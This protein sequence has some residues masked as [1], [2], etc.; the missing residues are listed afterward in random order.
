MRKSESTNGTNAAEK[1]SDS[2][3]SPALTPVAQVA[4]HTPAAAAR[5]I[6]ASSGN[7]QG[8]K[9]ATRPSNG[10]GDVRWSRNFLAGKT[11][12]KPDYEDV[13]GVA[14]TKAASVQLLKASDQYFFY[15]L[16]GPGGRL[17][18]HPIVDKG[19]LP[20][21]AP[22]FSC[23]SD[24][25]DFAVDSFDGKRVYIACADAKIYVFE[26]PHKLE[27]D[28]GQASAVLSDGMDKLF[29][30][31]SHPAIRNLLLSVS[32]DK[33]SAH[34][35][36]WDTATGEAICK[37]AVSGNGVSLDRYSRAGVSLTSMT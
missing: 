14:T 17:A 25:V 23:G 15:P 32:D 28:V 6:P 33:G 2:V 13:H 10:K 18:I 19:R 5:T 12:L 8:H 35:R 31:Q 3:P 1:H 4:G 7:R 37:Q 22:S 16:A 36:V 26:V 21:H 9:V 20:T 24:I 11:A 27:G 34:V 30:L 29:E